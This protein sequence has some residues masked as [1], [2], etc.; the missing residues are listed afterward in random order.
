MSFHFYVHAPSLITFLIR[1]QFQVYFMLCDVNCDLQSLP[2]IYLT[3]CVALFVL[4]QLFCCSWTLVNIT[5]RFI[6]KYW[7]DISSALGMIVS[8]T[9]IKQNLKI[10]FPFPTC[11]IV[12]HMCTSMNQGAMLQRG[13]K[14]IG[15]LV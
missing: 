3:D 2:R 11:K 14:T 1:I 6:S 8:Q 4:F 5:S 9:L 13:S 12:E 15:A 7:H 10:T